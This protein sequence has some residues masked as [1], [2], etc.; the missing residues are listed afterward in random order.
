MNW[1]AWTIGSTDFWET[2]ALLL[3]IGIFLYV[4]LP[5]FITKALDDRANMIAKELDQ[6]KRLRAEA[7]T[8]LVDY[9]EKA[10]KAE[11]EAATILSDTRAEAQRQTAE[12]AVQLKIQ[13]ERRAKQAQDRIAQAEANAIAEIRA[14]AADAAAAAAG[15]LIAAR[16]DEKKAAAIVAQSL[17][18]LP[19]KLN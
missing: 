16:L 4:R 6:A 7:E 9:R 5:A 10:Q 17:G 1:Q 3:V 18:E 8:L 15:K 2:V 12:A 11:A 19:A 13:L 14:M